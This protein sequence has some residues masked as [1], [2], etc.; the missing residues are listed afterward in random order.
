MFLSN[1]WILISQAAKHQPGPLSWNTV[2]NRSELSWR[3]TSQAAV[4]VI[5]GL[6]NGIRCQVCSH[7]QDSSRCP[8]P[9]QAAHPQGPLPGKG[10]MM[11]WQMPK[12]SDPIGRMKQMLTFPVPSF[13]VGSRKEQECI[14]GS[15]PDPNPEKEGMSF[16]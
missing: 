15:Q 4:N 7:R 16:F 9:G 1:P 8:P 12:A 10:R 3:Q 13:A 14:S 6:Q 2:A 11:L 5:A